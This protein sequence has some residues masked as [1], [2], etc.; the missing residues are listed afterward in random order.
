MAYYCADV[1]LSNYSLTVGQYFRS[2]YRQVYSYTEVRRD[3]R[4][5][6][7]TEIDA[8]FLTPIFGATFIELVMVENLEFE[9]GISTLSVIVPEI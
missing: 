8:R 1:P 7:A 9:V 6:P 5:K 3:T 4:Q 2:L